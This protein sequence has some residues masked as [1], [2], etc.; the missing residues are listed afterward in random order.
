M[1][2]GKDKSPPEMP[3]KDLNELIAWLKAIRRPLPSRPL[4]SALLPCSFRKKQGRVLPWCPI[5]AAAQLC[6]TWGRRDACALKDRHGR[7]SAGSARGYLPRHSHGW[8]GG[9]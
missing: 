4:A 5:A 6:R 3:T 7:T 2:V 8:E 9:T 1:K